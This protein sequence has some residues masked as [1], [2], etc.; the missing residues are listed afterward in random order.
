MPVFNCASAFSG[1]ANAVRRRGSLVLLAFAVATAATTFDFSLKAAS[2][3]DVAILR[4]AAPSDHDGSGSGDIG[5]F[6]HEIARKRSLTEYQAPPVANKDNG[7]DYDDYKKVNF[8]PTRAVWKDEAHGYELHPLPMGWLFKRGIDISV[9]EGAE[10]L[11]LQFSALD[12][13]GLAEARTAERGAVANDQPVAISGFRLNG[14]LNSPDKADEIIVF[15]GASYFRA[16]A[17]GQTYGLSARGLAIATASPAGEEFPEFTSFWVEKPS[18]PGEPIVIHALLDSPSVAGAYRFAVRSGN[19]TVVRVDATLFPRKPLDNVGLAPLTSMNLVSPLTPGRIIDFRPRVHDSQGLAIHNANG[20]HVWRPLSNP[21]T[22]QISSFQGSSPKGFGL[23]QRER[24]FASYEDLEARYERRPSVWIEP[25]G[26][27]FENGEVVLV[28][29]PS[30]KEWHDNI[31]AFWRPRTRIE[32]GQTTTFSYTMRWRADVPEVEQAGLFVSQSRLGSAHAEDEDSLRFVIDYAA[33]RTF[34]EGAELPEASV[35]SSAGKVGK[36]T[37]QRNPETGGA[38][39]SFVF[40]PGGSDASELR[41]ILTEDG[42]PAGETWLYRWT[43][44]E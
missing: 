27:L 3:E 2:A 35:E 34:S 28:E 38:R 37:L 4:K 36:V 42:R 41:L 10:R 20:E 26:K 32:P 24:E 14:P 13:P 25:E 33:G 12:F 23:I 19:E 9:V 39:A 8:D 6:V 30:E 43:R 44:G 5:R 7:L 40:E 1:S 15:Q 18:E 11:P 16:L 31:V 17:K 22:L 29:I 21:R